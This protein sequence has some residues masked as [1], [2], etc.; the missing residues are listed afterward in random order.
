MLAALLLACVEMQTPSGVERVRG[1]LWLEGF[2]AND[3][4]VVVAVVANSPLPC[5][6]DPAADLPSTSVDEEASAVV[7][8]EAQLA[9][10][11]Y[12]EGAALLL[13][14][15]LVDPADADIAVAGALTLAGEPGTGSAV[16]LEVF[17][18]A[19][20]EHATTVLHS[21]ELKEFAYHRPLRGDVRAVVSDTTVQLSADLG[22]WE[23]VADLERCE[24]P[25]LVG[26]AI[27]AIDGLPLPERAVDD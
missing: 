11:L 21:Y 20:E 15:L 4:S 25:N 13:L 14:A 17:E 18:S 3:P 26:L 27:G 19:S 9:A 12:R 7:W 10:A 6:P 22:E 5:A 23:V 16:G 8:W 1:G 24:N 2:V